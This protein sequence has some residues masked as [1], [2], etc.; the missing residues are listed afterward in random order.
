MTGIDGAAPSRPIVIGVDPLA[1]S[2]WSA[3]GTVAGF[4]SRRPTRCSW[5]TP[6]GSVDRPR[7]RVLDIGCG[8]GPQCRAARASRGWL[9]GTGPVVADARGRRRDGREEP[10]WPALVPGR[11][12]T[13]CRFQTEPSTSH[14]ARHLEPGARSDEFR[15]GDRG[16]RPG[17]AARAALFVFTFSRRTLPASRRRSPGKPSCS[18]SSPAAAVFLTREQLL[19]EL[20]T[21]GFE[22]DPALPLR[23]LNRPRA[24]PGPF[25]EDAGHLRSRFPP[26]LRIAR[27][28]PL[29]PLPRLK[30]CGLSI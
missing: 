6:T 1:G 27:C 19:D 29:G 23:E 20:A 5:H 26:V 13:R 30:P 4:R 22:P 7:L 9:I 10:G 24:R 14:R 21:A 3:P 17:G 18:R 11:R 12:W 2:A 15:R 16:G 28:L 25:R 8:A